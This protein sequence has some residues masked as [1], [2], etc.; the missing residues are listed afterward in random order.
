VE[1]VLMEIILNG[2]HPVGP[3]RH[4]GCEG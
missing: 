2:D 4:C 1:I 3:H